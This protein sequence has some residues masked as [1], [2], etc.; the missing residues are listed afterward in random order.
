MGKGRHPLAPALRSG[1]MIQGRVESV[2]DPDHV[3][4]RVDEMTLV[5]QTRTELHTGDQV[6]LCAADPGRPTRFQVVSRK[7]PATGGLHVRT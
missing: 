6:V 7:N 3:I 2:L 4:I 1:Q 5:A